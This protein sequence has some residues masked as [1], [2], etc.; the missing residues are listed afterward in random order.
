MSYE[1]AGFL[2]LLI[3]EYPNDV[4]DFYQIK[5]L[6][7]EQPKELE[8]ELIKEPPERI[9]GVK[10]LQKILEDREQKVYMQL[11]KEKKIK[12]KPKK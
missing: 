10:L 1:Q 3:P 7:M 2:D 4:C 5:H 8:V 9:Y 6:S 11:K 12:K